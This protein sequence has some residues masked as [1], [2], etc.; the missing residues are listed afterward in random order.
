[1]KWSI[2]VSYSTSVDFTTDYSTIRK[3]VANL[4]AFLGE[5]PWK[6][7][8]E[9]CLYGATKPK[10]LKRHMLLHGKGFLVAGKTIKSCNAVKKDG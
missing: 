8:F 4:F 2:E 3:A 7:T 5:K 6:C 10:Y 9:G 1:M